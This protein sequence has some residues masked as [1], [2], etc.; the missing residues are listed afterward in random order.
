MRCASMSSF[1]RC[2]SFAYVEFKDQDAVVNAVI[3][4]ESEFKG[5]QLK[6]TPK[7]TNIHGHN[8]NTGT[9]HTTETATQQHRDTGNDMTC[10]TWIG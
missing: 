5:R 1:H 4:N 9:Q 6:I 7:R 8:S 10:A 2:P 3:L